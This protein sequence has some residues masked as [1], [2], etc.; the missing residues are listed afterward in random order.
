[1]NA[2][3]C[4]IK[5][6][7][8]AWSFRITFENEADDV[9]LLPIDAIKRSGDRIGLQFMR[10]GALIEPVEFMIVSPSKEPA[11]V[12]LLPNEQM[13]V[14]FIG[15]LEE[16]APGVAALSFSH[17]VYRIELGKHYKVGFS[18]HDIRSG[19]VDWSVE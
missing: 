18:W 19:F 14:E 5:H 9:A 16:K 17:A 13:E 4:V 11:A 2:K 8:R 10:D 3:I 6:E 12:Q 7:Q 1:M 15:K